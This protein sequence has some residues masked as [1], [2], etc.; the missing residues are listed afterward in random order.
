MARKPGNS[1]TVLGLAI[2]GGLVT[3]AAGLVAALIAL[4]ND[5]MVGMGVCLGAA[6]LA[7]GLVANAALR[8]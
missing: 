8:Q 4:I 6:A 5:D 7:F 3:G 1:D 2:V